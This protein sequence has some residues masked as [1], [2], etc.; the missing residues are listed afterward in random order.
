M[1]TEIQKEYNH[2]TRKTNFTVILL[3]VVSIIT[4]YELFHYQL[5][6]A[7]FLFLL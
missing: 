7:I 5:L 4:F 1:L 3:L 6:S 2:I